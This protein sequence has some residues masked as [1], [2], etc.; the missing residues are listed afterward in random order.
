MIK[1][2]FFMY[3]IGNAGGIQEM[4]I[5]WMKKIDRE[6]VHIDILSYNNVRPDNF[7]E[8][9]KELGGNV[10]VIESYQDKGMF[11][12]S[13]QQTYSFFKEHHYDILHAHSSSK[14]VF[15]LHAAKRAGVKVRILHSH[16]TQFVM[17]G[18]FPLLVA[19][20]FKKPAKWLTTNYMA[21]S[22]E[23]G[24][25]LFGEEERRRNNLFV[26]HNGIDTTE[27]SPSDEIRRTKRTELFGDGDYFVVGHVGRFMPQKNH[28]FL[29]DIFKAVSELNPSVRFVCVGGGELEEQIHQKAEDLGLSDKI[30]FTGVRNDVKDLMQAFDLMVMPS[31][32]EGLPVAGV[33]AQAVG[34][35]VLFADTITKDAPILPMSDF[36]SLDDSPMEWAKKIVSY[37][38]LSRIDNPHKYIREK[39][40]DIVMETKRLEDFYFSLVNSTK[41]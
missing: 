33:E 13:L 18:K 19:R 32:F 17:T 27:F 3:S 30:V 25:F 22:P 8:R 40:Y 5:K 6:K 41:R 7:I 31:L 39:G 34:T 23:A 10:Y 38:K 4:T 29:M 9:V 2:L 16:A 20:I 35:P 15:V 28:T 21:C 37:M 1:V 14:A 12:K 11:F 36:M 26:A 24:D